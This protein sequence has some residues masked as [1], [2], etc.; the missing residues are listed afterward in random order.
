MIQKGD[1]SWFADG[2]AYEHYVGRWSR[3]VGQMFL[4]WL[5]LPP[6]LCWVDVGCGTGAL[7]GILLD[8]AD[9]VR[10]VGVEPSEGFLSVARG[11][12]EDARAE[13][14]LGD[15]RAL[16]LDAEEADVA[17]SGLVLN[18][19]PDKQRALEEMRRIVKPGSTVA[20]Y[21]WDYAGEMQLMRYFWTAVADLFPD[22]AERDEGKQFPICKPDALADLFR[23]A[24]LRAV[25]THALDA[26]TV[27]T[28]FDDYWSPFLRGQGPAGAYCVSLSET[29]RERLRRR[30]E[31][32]LPFNADGTID[33]IAR[34]W[35]VRGTV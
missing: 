26:P 23:V 15:A 13:F 18:F 29:D 12:V 35:A 19:V 3:P 1:S 16:P 14:R 32:M 8:R 10:V 5:S 7:T 30:L 9:P 24:D 4:D 31:N 28:D 27:F 34:A 25:E 6:G 21:V 22:G 11:N 17:V 2:E 33:L 20:S